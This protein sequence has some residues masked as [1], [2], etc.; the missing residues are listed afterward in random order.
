M[1][2]ITKIL[3]VIMAAVML[4]AALCVSAGAESIE[5]TAKAIDSGKKV[6]FTPEAGTIW[7]AP[8]RDYKVI[9]SEK[10][11][12]RLTFNTRSEKTEV[13]VMDSNGNRIA[14]SDSNVTTGW[15]SS[16]KIT[17]IH[18]NTNVEKF[19]GKLYYKSLKKG[20]YYVRIRNANSSC[21]VNGKLSVSFKYPQKTEEEATDGTISC[22]SVSLKNGESLQFGAVIEG[23]GTVEWSS[24]KKSVAAVSS[25]GKITAKSKGTAT[26]EAKLGK[27][28]VKIKVNVTE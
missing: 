15:V 24:T 28:S 7:G 26:I 17:S 11:T 4:V 2:K 27:S 18:W 19:S 1:K 25:D 3:S 16:G 12:L 22:L 21:D 23:E 6:S 14:L 20:T 5:D 9:L 13:E 8:S 10:G